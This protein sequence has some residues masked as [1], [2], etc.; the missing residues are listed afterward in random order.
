[1]CQRLLC[2]KKQQAKGGKFL[3]EKQSVDVYKCHNVAE[4]MRLSLLFFVSHSQQSQWTSG[5]RAGMGKEKPKC[6]FEFAR[7]LGVN[8]FII[9][10]VVSC[11]VSTRADSMERKKE[12]RRG[13]MV[14][15]ST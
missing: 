13:R 14:I 6:H 11:V 10:L 2:V 1:M 15:F 3:G 4:I 9:V 5:K 8:F 7:K 12:L